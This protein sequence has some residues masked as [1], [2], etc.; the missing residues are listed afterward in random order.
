ME[1]PEL[2]PN[3]YGKLYDKVV[4]QLV[5]EVMVYLI[6]GVDTNDYSFW[7]KIQLNPYLKPDIKI[8][9]RWT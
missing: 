6:N 5:G 3:I 8:N 9:P 4:F 7:K 1:F 2:E